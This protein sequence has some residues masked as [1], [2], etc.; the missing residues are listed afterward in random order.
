[1]MSNASVINRKKNEGKEI[2]RI[3]EAFASRGAEILFYFGFVPLL[4][5]LLWRTTAFPQFEQAEFLAMLFFTF[6]IALKMLLFDCWTL[7]EVIFLVLCLGIAGMSY[8][9][10]TFT[11]PLVLIIAIY[12]AR[13]LD[14]RK[15]LKVWL[16]M[17]VLNLVIAMSGAFCGIIENYSAEWT[18]E[19]AVSDVKNSLGIIHSTDC[20]ARIFYTSLVWMYLRGE[21][22][23]WFEY[24]LAV[25]LAA[26]TFYVTGGRIDSGC[27]AIAAVLFFVTGWFGHIKYISYASFDS[28]ARG[29]GV[30]WERILQILA[31]VSFPNGAAVSLFLCR[32]YTKSGS[33]EKLNKWTSNRLKIGHEIFDEYKIR[34][35]GQFIKMY[36]NGNGGFNPYIEGVKYN[37]IDIS[38][39]S[40]LVLYGIAF[41]ALILG[42]YVYLAYSRRKDLNLM[43]CIVMIAVNCMIAHHL[44]ELAYVSFVLLVF[45]RNGADNVI[46]DK[47]MMR[48][49]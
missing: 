23:K 27:I 11:R 39:Q 33:F 28:P 40:I 16:V 5:V 26:V 43:I 22:L 46:K 18:D 19:D 37:F 12:G 3:R 25:A 42:L 20:A 29:F 47:Y 4:W 17:S 31:L 34:L 2:A 7:K 45:A 49:S 1:M 14:G 6:C 9:K 44:T 30:L 32:I 13:G 38:Y 15:I 41:F 48:R 10:S 36:G 8:Y 21:R 24:F 35:F